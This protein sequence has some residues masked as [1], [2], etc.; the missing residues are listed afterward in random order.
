MREFRDRT[1][2]NLT[3]APL[4]DLAAYLG[5]NVGYVEHISDGTRE[6]A[7]QCVRSERQI[8]ISMKWPQEVQHYTLAHE[9]GH[10]AMHPQL[11][12]VHR[13]PPMYGDERERSRSHLEI[14]ADRFA[15]ELKPHT[16]KNMI[17]STRRRVVVTGIGCVNPLGHDVDTVWKG[18][19]TCQSGVAPTT[20]FDASNFPT[21]ISAEVKD[22]DVAKV[23]EDLARWKHVGRH[24]PVIVP[25]AF[26]ALV[27]ESN[28]GATPGLAALAGADATLLLSRPRKVQ[29]LDRDGSQAPR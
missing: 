4:D 15:A 16:Y 17:T 22:W 14:E 8:L 3:P 21:R 10:V 24:A 29:R 20:I 6:F 13:D 7:G 28:H 9:L 23:G 1:R 27:P 11:P 25:G 19:L 18:L 5:W 26:T 12:N 2:K